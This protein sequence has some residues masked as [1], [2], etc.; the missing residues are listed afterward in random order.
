MNL[1]QEQ[2]NK[3][4]R[5]LLEANSVEELS[6]RMLTVF[7]KAEQP[8]DVSH[9]RVEG[10]GVEI[11]EPAMRRLKPSSQ[12]LYCRRD[13][14][15]GVF[16]WLY[17]RSSQ[18]EFWILRTV[19]L[20]VYDCDPK[21]VDLS[22]LRGP[23]GF[24]VEWVDFRD[25]NERDTSELYVMDNPRCIFASAKSG[26][27]P[28]KRRIIVREVKPKARQWI[29]T[30]CLNKHKAHCGHRHMDTGAD[31]HKGNSGP[32]ATVADCADLDDIK[33]QFAIAHAVGWSDISISDRAN[34]VAAIRHYLLMNPTR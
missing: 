6:D 10:Q 15:N 3:L 16:K 7:G 19:P 31:N 33:V 9:L 4:A 22:N 28:D 32:W 30:E 14:A 29:A 11:A 20:S 21:S 17:N 8:P 12:E 34:L 23:N 24:P 2:A 26:L 5:V 27:F 1:N 13:L 18:D 25:I